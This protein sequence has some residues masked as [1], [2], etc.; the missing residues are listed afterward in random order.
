MIE[1]WEKIGRVKGLD[2]SFVGQIIFVSAFRLRKFEI[3]YFDIYE[4]KKSLR[5][6]RNKKTEVKLDVKK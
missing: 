3:V 6:L 4:L 1:V 5:W 2:A